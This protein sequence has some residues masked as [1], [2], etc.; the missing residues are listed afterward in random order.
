M[1][2]AAGRPPDNWALPDIRAGDFSPYWRTLDRLRTH[3]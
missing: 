1:L 2:T 3:N